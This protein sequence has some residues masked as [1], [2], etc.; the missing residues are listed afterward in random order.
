MW[1]F[2]KN[3]K[4]TCPQMKA[5]TC[6]ITSWVFLR[7]S[8]SCETVYSWIMRFCE[9][10][11][12]Q[13]QCDQQSTFSWQLLPFDQIAYLVCI[14]KIIEAAVHDNFVLL[15]LLTHGYLFFLMHLS[16]SRFLFLLYLL[17]RSYSLS[18]DTIH[19]IFVWK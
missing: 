16:T 2:V 11:G 3:K 17:W 13:E 15:W 8:L 10:K 1:C 14:F 18:Y 7:C 12:R 9:F 19:E 6:L 5:V 4:I